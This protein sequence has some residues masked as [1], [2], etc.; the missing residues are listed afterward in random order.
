MKTQWQKKVT[1]VLKD[2]SFQVPKPKG[3]VDLDTFQDEE[4]SR[5]EAQAQ[6]EKLAELLNGS[7]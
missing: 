7:G 6:R 5:E 3:V 2:E 4:I 1:L